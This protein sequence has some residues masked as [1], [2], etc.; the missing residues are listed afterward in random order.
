M[1]VKR[2]HS[3]RHGK[4]RNGVRQRY[5]KSDRK[6]ERE[7]NAAFHRF[8]K[9]A[10]ADGPERIDHDNIAPTGAHDNQSNEPGTVPA[11]GQ[12]AERKG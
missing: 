4:G 10:T 1:G 8:Y 12:N 11:G 7:A 3:K 2:Q 9:L 6:R 5:H